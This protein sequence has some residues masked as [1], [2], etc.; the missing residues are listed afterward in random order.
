MEISSHLYRQ[1]VI[2]SIASGPSALHTVIS[3]TGYVFSVSHA[4]RGEIIVRNIEK[5]DGTQ[6]HISVGELVSAIW[7]TDDGMKLI[8]QSIDLRFRV[9]RFSDDKQPCNE[10]A[11][12]SRVFDRSDGIATSRDSKLLAYHHNKCAS[13][14]TIINLDTLEV[15]QELTGLPHSRKIAISGNNKT[16]ATCVNTKT[17]NLIGCKFSLYDIATKKLITTRY[18]PRTIYEITHTSGKS[19]FTMISK[20]NEVYIWDTVIDNAYILVKLAVEPTFACP[21][22]ALNSDKTMVLY[23]SNIDTITLQD[24]RRRLFYRITNARPNP[25]MKFSKDDSVFFLYNKEK[26]EIYGTEFTPFWTTKKH[27]TFDTMHRKTIRYIFI[28]HQ[29]MRKREMVGQTFLLQVPTEV[30]ALILSFIRIEL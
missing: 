25:I 10:N 13:N 17:K 23:Q 15:V 20:Q 16:L 28:S 27:I 7:I 12:P 19:E 4:P 22:F 1:R 9:W 24:V 14:V 18:I 8:I 29:V 3:N 11:Q 6:T 21:E 30:L 2:K 26:F 5:E